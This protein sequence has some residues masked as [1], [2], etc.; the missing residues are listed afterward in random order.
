[1]LEEY[2]SYVI[3]KST[4]AIAQFFGNDTFIAEAI[5][6]SPMI[7]PILLF[8]PALALLAI[9]L[10]V[11][12]IKD[13]WKMPFGIALELLALYFYL[14][15]SNWAII[16]AIVSASLFFVLGFQQKILRWVYSGVGFLKFLF[17]APFFPLPE[18]LKALI[19]FLPI[20][21]VAMFLLCI[22]D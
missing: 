14:K 4:P 12:F 5:L 7:L 8:V 3:E 11:D 6:S 16:F 19:A 17:I 13:S 15:S 9:S 2:I 18:G 10:F 21:T 1:M 20:L 22:T